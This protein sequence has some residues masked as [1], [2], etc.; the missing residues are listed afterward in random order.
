MLT[1]KQV[2]DRLKVSQATVLRWV[3]M[4]WLPAFYASTYDIE[5]GCYA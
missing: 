4:G 1:T 5:E 3:N 2:A